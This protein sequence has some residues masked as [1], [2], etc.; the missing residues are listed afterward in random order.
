M[1]PRLSLAT[2]FQFSQ[3][4]YWVSGCGMGCHLHQI[5][6]Q[7]DLARHAC[8]CLKK[9]LPNFHALL[10]LRG[11]FR[12]SIIMCEEIILL[13]SALSVRETEVLRGDETQVYPVLHCVSDS[14]NQILTTS[15][16]EMLPHCILGLCAHRAL[17]VYVC[18]L[19]A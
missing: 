3:S 13:S 1:L 6:A 12:V 15:C 16:V 9:T 5:C 19:S 14:R 2:C 18:V 7:E 8:A 10:I 17:S 4:Y 11:E